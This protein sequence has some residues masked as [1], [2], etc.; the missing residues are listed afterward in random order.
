VRALAEQA[1]GDATLVIFHTAVL[2]YVPDLGE[3]RQFTE[4]VRRLGA[5]SIANEGADLFATPGPSADGPWP[6]GQFL[7]TLNGT[8]IART[9]PHGAALEWLET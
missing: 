7:L 4:T 6:S 1:P 8:P 2:A 5:T 9:D 3:R